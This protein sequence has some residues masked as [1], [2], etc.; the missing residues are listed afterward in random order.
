MDV[1]LRAIAQLAPGLTLHVLFSVLAVLAGCG[2]NTGRTYRSTT[3]GAGGAPVGSDSGASSIAAGGVAAT[4]STGGIDVATGGVRRELAATGGQM[5]PADPNDPCNGRGLSDA[6]AKAT[7]GGGDC[8]YL[9]DGFAPVDLNIYWLRG[10]AVL[11]GEG[12]IIKLEGSESEQYWL[13]RLSVERWPCYAG[14]TFEYVCS[15]VI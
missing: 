8:V 4:V 13:D 3:A 14:R 11:D 6:I 15:P 1:V 2:G 7:A 5:Y 10:T 9:R 12:R